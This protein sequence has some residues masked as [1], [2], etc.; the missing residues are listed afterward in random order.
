MYKEENPTTIFHCK[1]N[2]KVTQSQ[3]VA[4]SY[5]ILQVQNSFDCGQII[6][7][8]IITI[9]NGKNPFPFPEIWVIPKDF[10]SSH[11][12]HWYHINNNSL[13]YY[14]TLYE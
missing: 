1:W 8:E 12:M 6:I 14:Y 3:Q 11:K 4:L 13:Y 10:S 7:M 9:Q 2:P 5:H